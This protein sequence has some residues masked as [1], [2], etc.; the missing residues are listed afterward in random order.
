[1]SEHAR[2]VGKTAMTVN[3]AVKSGVVSVNPKLH[4]APQLPFGGVKASGFGREFDNLG[5]EYFIELRTILLST[6]RSGAA[7]PRAA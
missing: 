3:R 7:L 1:M 5:F 4:R 2:F 6:A